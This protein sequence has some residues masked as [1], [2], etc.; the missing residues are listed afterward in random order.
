MTSSCPKHIRDDEEWTFE[1]RHPVATNVTLVIMGFV[2]LAVIIFGAIK[3]A[4]NPPQTLYTANERFGL[5]QDSSLRTSII[6]DDKTGVYYL[7]IRERDNVAVTP[8]LNLDGL[9]V[10]VDDINYGDIVMGLHDV[11]EN[12]KG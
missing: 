1:H 11:H 7:V 3:F 8:L 6:C 9:P 4:S 10:C 5:A 2:I 12:L